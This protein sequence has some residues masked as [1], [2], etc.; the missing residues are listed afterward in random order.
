MMLPLF[1]RRHSGPSSNHARRRTRIDL[2]R[3]GGSCLQNATRRRA[4][5]PRLEQLEGRVVLSSYTA[6]TVS[7]LIA[8]INASN[9]AGGPNTITLSAPSSSPYFLTS[10][11]NTT[12]GPTGLPVVAANR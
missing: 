4:R 7:D 2:D 10:V 6:A 8:D 9:H 1:R 11:D 3:L 5:R 12:D